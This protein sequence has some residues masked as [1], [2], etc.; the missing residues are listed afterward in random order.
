MKKVIIFLGGEQ[1]SGKS[2]ATEFIHDKLTE[3]SF[4][5]FDLKFA[6]PIYDIA[7]D[8]EER[9]C[10]LVGKSPSK[11]NGAL[12]QKLGDIG[13]EVYSP[14]I[15][16]KALEQKVTDLISDEFCKDINKCVII[17]DTRTAAE[18]ALA[19]TLM[20][21]G[22]L[23][24]TIYFD[25]PEE[26][27]KP[28]THSWRENTSHITESAHTFQD[29]FRYTVDTSGTK[30]D[31]NFL[32]E[33]ILEGVNLL[34]EPKSQLD[35]LVD[36]FN[37][38]YGNWSRKTGMG[39]NFDWRFAKDG[40]KELVVRDLGKIETLPEDKLAIRVQETIDALEPGSPGV[41]DGPTEKD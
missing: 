8:V 9:M 14:D 38:C 7:K 5:C 21:K 28:R 20:D 23:V 36:A 18:L 32:L 39:A 13:R 34:A 24:L 19:Q 11:K 17:E 6:G 27:R 15:W 41:Q 37:A 1:G 35:E 26:I 12:L 22:Y 4:M 16:I 40:L 25:A 31:K 30:E 10:A 29:Q 33:S 2:S 3:N